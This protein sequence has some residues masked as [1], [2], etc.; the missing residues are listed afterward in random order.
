MPTSPVQLVRID[1]YSPTQMLIEW[2]TG[3][4]FAVPFT[5][6]RYLCPCAGCVDEN[7]GRRTIQRSSVAATLRP[8]EAQVV[9][10]YAIQIRWADGHE[11]G[12]YH[13]DYFHDIC[14]AVGKRI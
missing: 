1:S 14:G 7:T 9:G 6:I 11:T 4:R 5:E 8:K 10:R 2:N 13:F 3:E 12:I